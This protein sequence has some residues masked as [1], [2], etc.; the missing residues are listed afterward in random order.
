M[1]LDRVKKVHV[2][3]REGGGGRTA[4]FESHRKPR[5]LNFNVALGQQGSIGA[6]KNNTNTERLPILG[7]VLWLSCAP[8]FTGVDRPVLG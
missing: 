1:R 3:G 5:A 8:A 2:L 6:A 4:R 7:R